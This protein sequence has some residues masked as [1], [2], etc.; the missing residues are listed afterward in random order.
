[1]Q[2][3]IGRILVVDDSKLM[4]DLI[5]MA[6]RSLGATDVES[7]A[8]GREALSYLSTQKADLVIL[9]WVLGDIDGLECVR[10]I[11]AGTTATA[12]STPIIMISG[13][14]PRAA[15]IDALEAGA[16]HFMPKPFTLAQL[17]EG[18]SIAVGSSTPRG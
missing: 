18:L 12:G 8:S 7:A 11:R 5:S 10:R 9:D 17:M 13:A 16:N 2:G 3:N 15:G 4:R 6:L 14:K 1:M